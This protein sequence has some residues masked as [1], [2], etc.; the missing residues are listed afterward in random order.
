MLADQVQDDSP[1][2]M[3]GRFAR[4]HLEVSKVDFAHGES[5]FVADSNNSAAAR[6]VQPTFVNS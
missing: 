5:G 2:D 6:S 3:P 4:G 1:V